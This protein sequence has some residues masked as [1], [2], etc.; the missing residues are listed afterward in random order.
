MTLMKEFWLK[1]ETRFY[2]LLFDGK[3]MEV[4]LVGVWRISVNQK[5]THESIGW[6]KCRKE[7]LEELDVRGIIILK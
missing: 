1:E 7:S 4:M 6:V 3:I 2:Q 5:S